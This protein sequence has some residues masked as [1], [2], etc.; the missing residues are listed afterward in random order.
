MHV[1][2]PHPAASEASAGGGGAVRL[3]SA[4]SE[5]KQT[6][7]SSSAAASSQAGS[8]SFTCKQIYLHTRV[9]IHISDLR[10]S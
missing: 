6:R 2:R 4:I 1:C 3:F 5:M 10:Q 7:L 8:H 9:Y